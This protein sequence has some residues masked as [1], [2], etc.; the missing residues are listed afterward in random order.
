MELRA[1]IRRFSGR[2]AAGC[3]GILVASIVLIG[4]ASGSAVH[5][6]DRTASLRQLPPAAAKSNSPLRNRSKIKRVPHAVLQHFAIFR[7]HPAHS[8]SASV[9]DPV[10][11]FISLQPFGLNAGLTATVQT[12]AGSVW[13]TPGNGVLCLMA[14]PAQSNTPVGASCSTDTAADD[15]NMFLIAGQIGQPTLVAGMA[16][17]GTHS[18]VITRQAGGTETLPVVNNVYVAAFSGAVSSV[19]VGAT[20]YQLP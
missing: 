8:A 12:R 6:N 17:D 1:F 19:E 3:L 15:G 18:V 2:T 9:P 13:V 11:Q 20:S 4:P 7:R 16:P 14:A 5:R 10:K